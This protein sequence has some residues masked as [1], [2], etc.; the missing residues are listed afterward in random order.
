MDKYTVTIVGLG[1]VGYWCTIQAM[2]AIA[3]TLGESPWTI[4][5]IDFDTVDERAV[6]KGFPDDLIGQPKPIAVY[7][8]IKRIFGSKIATH[9]QPI[10]AAAEAVPGHIAN[11]QAVFSCV[12]AYG[13]AAFISRLAA[14]NWQCRLSTAGTEKTKAIHNVEIFP[15]HTATL[16]MA[17]DTASWMAASTHRSCIT[18][19][20]V[21]PLAGAAF[22]LGSI[23]GALAVQAWLNR[24]SELK[25]YRLTAS[26]TQFAKIEWAGAIRPAPVETQ[27][28]FANNATIGTLWLH[29]VSQ[30]NVKEHEILIE[31]ELPWAIRQCQC[32]T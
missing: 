24:D 15:P 11:S 3:Q 13:P 29:L 7:T 32:G 26:G 5:L 17:Y 2:L 30:L 8:V 12:D 31:F 20:P 1:N 9:A 14:A 18:G 25:P 27:L 23:T 28:P 16:E 4:Q 10:V 19:D 6:K 21:N 22:P